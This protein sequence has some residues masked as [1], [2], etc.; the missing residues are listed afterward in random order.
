[1]LSLWQFCLLLGIDSVAMANTYDASTPVASHSALEA[2]KLSPLLEHEGTR[3][4]LF[5][6]STWTSAD[7]GTQKHPVI[8]FM[9]GAGGVN[10]EPNIRGQSMG[11]R[12]SSSD[13][14][15]SMPFIVL[16]PVTPS[17]GWEQL[18]EPSMKILD[19]VMS[20]LGGDPSRMYV[21]GQSMGGNGAWL[22]GATYPEKFAAVV[23]VCGHLDRDAGA[24]GQ[25]EKVTAN[26]KKKPIWAFH[27]ASDSVVP[28]EFTDNAVKALR[29]LGSDVKY[30]RYDT[31]PPCVL[32]SGKELPGHG[33]YELAFNDPELYKWLMEQ[34]LSVPRSE[35]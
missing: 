1:M 18:F 22:M 32:D 34:K 29:D 5:M 20:T 30:T 12:L 28:V 13:S 25:L 10:N 2:G 3:Y 21:L 27:A 33:S 7:A 23:P 35:L 9:H 19:V 16:L 24:A 8:L 14:A 31:A 4:M 26:L 17:R 6:P 15:A 11:R